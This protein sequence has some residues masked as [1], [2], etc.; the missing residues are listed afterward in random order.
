MRALVLILLCIAAAVPANAYMIR[1]NFWITELDW[2]WTG[3]QVGSGGFTFDS[4]WFVPV[5]DLSDPGF[6]HY[7]G[8]VP[9]D[10][11]EDARVDFFAG[12]L[13]GAHWDFSDI[14]LWRREFFPIE[15]GVGIAGWSWDWSGYAGPHCLLGGGDVHNYFS[16]PG[17]NYQYVS[18]WESHMVSEDDQGEDEQASLPEPPTI[19]LV[20]PWIV[21]GYLWRRR[22]AAGR[23]PDRPTLTAA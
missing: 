1:V 13:A 15:E 21:V 17:S 4:D 18:T 12:E 10:E 9:A 14:S 19:A 8:V 22:V 20:V 5:D 11:L 23:K 7:L 3:Q 16:I 2:N 6:Y